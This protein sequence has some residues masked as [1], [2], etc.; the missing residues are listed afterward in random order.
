[1]VLPHDDVLLL[2][3]PGAAV[4]VQRRALGL[5]TFA[6]LLAADA[7]GVRSASV[8]LT[9]DHAAREL[10][11]D[12]AERCRALLRALLVA[13]LGA[14]ARPASFLWLGELPDDVPALWRSL[15][16]LAVP[17][18][19]PPL[20]DER[21]TQVAERLLVVAERA[22]FD[23]DELELWALRRRWLDAGARAVEADFEQ[24]FVRAVERRGA[25]AAV[26]LAHAIEC[27]LEIGAVRRARARLERHAAWV[28]RDVRLAQLE[29]WTRVALDDPPPQARIW[30]STLPSA[31]IEWRDSDSSARPYLSGKEPR[32]AASHA[33]QE[34]AVTYV[35]RHAFGASVLLVV[36]AHDDGGREALHDDVA[37]GLRARYAAWYASRE[38]APRD[39]GAPERDVIA[40]AKRVVARRAAGD[41]VRAA[42]TGATCAALAVEP[43]LDRRGEVAGWLWLEFEHRLVPSRA[44]LER[45]ARAWSSR[46]LDARDDGVR[47][48]GTGS[49]PET[50]RAARPVGA[51]ADE[52]SARSTSSNSSAAVPAAAAERAVL[53]ELFARLVGDFEM[54]TAQRQWWGFVLEGERPVCVAS[55]G[56]AL[57]AHPD[58]ELGAQL[59]SHAGADGAAALRPTLDALGSREPRAPNGRPTASG[60]PLANGWPPA[61][62]RQ[63]P[64]GRGPARE[65]ERARILDRALRAHGWVGFHEPAPELSV[66]PDAASGVALA[67]ELGGK[68][69]LLLAIES[70][71]RRD[72]RP[73]DLERWRAR[74]AR[75]AAEFAAAEFRAWHRRT[76][77]HDV[78][79]GSG[80]HLARRLDEVL[81]ACGSR[82]PI[83]LVGPPGAGKSVLAR[84]L[85]FERGGDRRGPTVLAETAW[86][87]AD[88]VPTSRG[89]RS[90]T[91]WLVPRA[92]GLSADAQSGLVRWLADVGGQH[93]MSGERV[94][95]TLASSP[96]E[97]AE[98]GV[99]SRELAAAFAPLELRVA[100]LSA[101]RHEIPGLLACLLRRGAEREARPLPE[102]TD[103]AIACLWRREWRRNVRELEAVAYRLVVSAAGRTVDAQTVVQELERMGLDAP[104]K[105][106]S[107]RAERAW[108]V[109]ALETTR[110]TSGSAN[111][112]RAAAYLGWDPD[113]LVTKLRSFGID[114]DLPN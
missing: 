78:W 61:N 80:V 41:D 29:Q 82:A 10:E 20:P 42:L 68:V 31:L 27:A 102:L 81:A 73:E 71:R 24:G 106:P 19:H 3:L 8:A 57:G 46:V 6:R 94:I 9:L 36:C 15:G 22:G 93:V 70:S 4:D 44:D 64:R 79:L 38:S 58:A 110:H 87:G 59:G 111:K 89:A 74:A 55:G 75:R 23:A 21:A 86:V 52:R 92:D 18:A 1:M 98:R 99:W 33:D 97:L 84:W 40:T 25:L 100:A 62:G 45:A 47:R 53:G 101:H 90:A 60:W 43:V 26:W 67:F 5:T 16:D 50:S 108:L 95:V 49:G 76:Y 34:Q 66:H 54:K 103:D 63:T 72:F 2:L 104:E 30:T 56:S 65:P 107:R 37:A 109:Q 85:H 112:T 88:N 48:S 96:A 17:G 83:A 77:Q 69:R 51:G 39:P 114:P 113:T 28:A 14:A 7:Q 13:H 11:R 105:L 32:A 91:T 35:D 12:G